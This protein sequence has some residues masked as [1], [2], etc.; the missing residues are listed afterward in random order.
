[1]WWL[2]CVLCVFFP[3][4]GLKGPVA[5]TSFLLIPL[6]GSR[7]PRVSVSL[8][9]VKLT[10]CPDP[11]TGEGRDRVFAFV[12]FSLEPRRLERPT[13]ERTEGFRLIRD[14]RSRWIK[15]G[16]ILTYLLTYLI[17]ACKAMR[18]LTARSTAR[19][20]MRHATADR[21]GACPVEAPFGCMSMCEVRPM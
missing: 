10:P 8:L 1:M 5:S 7:W 20:V 15:K 3:I 19:V 13:S 9:Y 17:G 16:K 6:P 11:E 21:H 18:Y 12:R 2:C 14:P 4:C